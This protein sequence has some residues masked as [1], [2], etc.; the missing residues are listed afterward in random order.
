MFFPTFYVNFF[1][2][3]FYKVPVK[4]VTGLL[5]YGLVLVVFFVFAGEHGV[6]SVNMKVWRFYQIRDLCFI[7]LVVS[8][9]ALLP[10]LL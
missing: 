5:V 4:A 8:S 6:L 1:C 10:P 3:M 2:F 9:F 7:F